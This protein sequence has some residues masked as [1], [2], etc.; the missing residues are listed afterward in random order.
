MK[1]NKCIYIYLLFLVISHLNCTKSTPMSNENDTN[2][3][4]PIEDEVSEA[5]LLPTSING[6][7]ELSDG[8]LW[9]YRITA[10]EEIQTQ[11]VPLI[12][13]LHWGGAEGTFQSYSSCLVEPAF[14]SLPCILF[15]PE[16]RALGWSAEENRILIEG[17]VQLAIKH[18]PIDPD[19]IAITGYSNGGIGT[20][21]YINEIPEYFSAAIPM[22]GSYSSNQKIDLPVYAIH[23]SNDEL[24]SV[25][26]ASAAINQ[27]IELGS[28]IEWVV[29]DGLGHY[30]ACEYVPY[31]KEAVEWLNEE[32]WK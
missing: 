26:V 13:A 7:F 17:F 29:A 3:V 15:A 22:A 28:S 30:A 4:V 1:I 27:S 31:L 9:N 25:S 5:L 32:V 16:D 19:R 11:K 14:E 20:W 21:S 12:I 6:S 18:W 8:T 24:F 10:P 2:D 23:G